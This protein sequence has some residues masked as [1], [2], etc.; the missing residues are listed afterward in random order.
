MYIYMRWEMTKFAGIIPWY[1][2]QI[3]MYTFNVYGAVCQLCLDKTER[4]KNFLSSK[5]ASRKGM[6][7]F[8]M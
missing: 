1:I 3:I 8:C 5:E 6:E 4:K 2:C 7:S